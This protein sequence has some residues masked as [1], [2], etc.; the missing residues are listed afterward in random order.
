MHKVLAAVGLAA[1]FAGPAIAGG[2]GYRSKASQCGSFGKAD[3][4]G[5]CSVET[6][7]AWYDIRI[8]YGSIN[9]E[10]VCE[11]YPPDGYC[12]CDDYGIY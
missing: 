12:G 2:C 3:G 5:G 10:K 8:S 9:A 6:S 11:K 1:L 4:L 7:D